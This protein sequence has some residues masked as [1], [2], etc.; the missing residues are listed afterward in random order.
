MRKGKDGLY[1]KL[2]EPRK[3]NKVKIMNRIVM[4]PMGGLFPTSTSEV[5]DRSKTYFV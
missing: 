1:M 5:S 4:L 2:F 3:I